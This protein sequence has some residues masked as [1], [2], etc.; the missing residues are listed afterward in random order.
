MFPAS[1][2]SV[3][4]S[5]CQETHPQR[6][7]WIP[8][9]GVE[10]WT[11]PGGNSD[12]KST[13]QSKNCGEFSLLS[14][15]EVLFKSRHELMNKLKVRWRRLIMVADEEIYSAWRCLQEANHADLAEVGHRVKTVDPRA[16]SQIIQMPSLLFPS[17]EPPLIFC[18]PG[19]EVAISPLERIGFRTSHES[20]WFWM[21]IFLRSKV[22]GIRI[23]RNMSPQH[24]QR[25]NEFEG[26]GFMKPGNDN[27]KC[28]NATAATE[29]VDV[30]MRA[31][32]LAKS[33]ARGNQQVCQ[34]L[35]F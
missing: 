35:R 11:S 24:H 14:S 5:S 23:K 6:C 2:V 19:C 32:Q 34:E 20:C 17:C 31:S 30:A 12:A 29:E 13:W 15:S 28:Q 18:N 3:A 9:A 16:E 10:R 25:M 4:M 27:L 8:T 33:L 7:R 26:V 22:K 21:W 1:N